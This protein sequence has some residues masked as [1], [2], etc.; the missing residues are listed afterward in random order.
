MAPYHPFGE[1]LDIVRR[2]RM[3]RTWDSFTAHHMLESTLDLEYSNGPTRHFFYKSKMNGG[4]GSP[5]LRPL[6]PPGKNST[7]AKEIKD[8]IEKNPIEGVIGLTTVNLK[9]NV[10]SM[11]LPISFINHLES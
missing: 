4:H 6:N 5:C 3:T 7:K 1:H 8:I 9:S 10:T 2:E 11:S